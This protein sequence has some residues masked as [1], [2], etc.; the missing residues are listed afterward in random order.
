MSSN[1]NTFAAENGRWLAEGQRFLGYSVG[2]F[3]YTP[4]DPESRVEVLCVATRPEVAAEACARIHPDLTL[5]KAQAQVIAMMQPATMRPLAGANVRN[6][7]P[8]SALIEDAL[9]LVADDAEAAG[10]VLALAVEA[11]AMSEALEELEAV[12]IAHGALAPDF[13]LDVVK[14]ALRGLGR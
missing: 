3:M 2:A 12:A 7:A 13:V 10:T 4:G 8:L 11:E 14:R 9:A 5:D 6:G 1:P